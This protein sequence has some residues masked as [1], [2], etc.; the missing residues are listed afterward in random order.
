[1]LQFSQYIRTPIHLIWKSLINWIKENAESVDKNLSK[2]LDVYK[3]S[4]N[5]SMDHQKEDIKKPSRILRRCE[6][7]R[8]TLY[9]NE[10]KR[11]PFLSQNVL[12][13]TRIIEVKNVSMK[14]RVHKSEVVNQLIYIEDVLGFLKEVD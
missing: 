2:P 1:M 6:G 10:T 3:V 9:L 7:A 4:L 8:G 14:I 11:Q 13:K 5:A 12:K